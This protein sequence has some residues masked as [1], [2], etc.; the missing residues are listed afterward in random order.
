MR[1]W[2]Q[3]LLLKI[4]IFFFCGLGVLLYSVMTHLLRMCEEIR[5]TPQHSVCVRVYVY[6]CVCV[7]VCVW[8]LCVCM[9]VY[10]CMWVYVCM[11][12]VLMVYIHIC[13]G[14]VSEYMCMW[15]VRILE[16][17]L[18]NSVQWLIVW[19]NC[20]AEPHCPQQSWVEPNLLSAW[21]GPL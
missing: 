8:A 1:P 2:V 4:K 3:S 7:H 19:A 10:L 16:V 13:V 5:F 6:I 17:F 11:Y 20:K 21:P 9:H 18:I 15:C 12:C 14:C